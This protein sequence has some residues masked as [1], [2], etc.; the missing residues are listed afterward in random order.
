MVKSDCFNSVK[1]ERHLFLS[2]RSS[3]PLKYNLIKCG[4]PSIFNP[5]SGDER[6]VKYSLHQ[7]DLPGSNHSISLFLINFKCALT[8]SR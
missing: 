6:T 5:S 7:L 1:D 4:T 3:F 8:A 2:I